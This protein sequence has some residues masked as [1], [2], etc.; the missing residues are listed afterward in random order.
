[1]SIMNKFHQYLNQI[2][3][4]IN[5]SELER[6]AGIPKGVLRRHYSWVST[7]SGYKI[8]ND[9]IPSIVRALCNAFGSV[10]FCGHQITYDPDGPAIFVRV[11]IKEQISKNIWTTKSRVDVY[12]DFS[13]VNDFIKNLQD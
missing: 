1:M 6:L 13:F 8:S 12:D 9:H 10:D 4:I 11:I 7:G 2:K 3:T 5:T